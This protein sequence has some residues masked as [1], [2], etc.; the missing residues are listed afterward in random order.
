M[1]WWDVVESGGYF[2]GWRQAGFQMLFAHASDP[3]QH[4]ATIAKQAGRGWL[5]FDTQTV[6]HHR[7]W[8]EADWKFYLDASPEVRA[9]RRYE[10]MLA[11]GQQV[12]YEGVLAALLARDG[13]DHSRAVA[14]LVKPEGAVEI[15][16]TDMTIEQV[17]QQLRRRVESAP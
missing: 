5:I 12:S 2:T 1:R 6:G 8:P 11:D 10:E 9:R 17:T 7:N 14:P 3:E 13:R 4:A 16:T 15:D